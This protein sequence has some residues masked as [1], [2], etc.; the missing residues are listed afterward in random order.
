[1]SEASE[2][3]ALEAIVKSAEDCATT[4][5]SATDA[6]TAEKA[7]LEAKLAQA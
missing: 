7:S 2:K 4:A 1:M 3:A 5:Q 6:A